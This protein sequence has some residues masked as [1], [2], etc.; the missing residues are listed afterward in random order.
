MGPLHDVTKHIE[1]WL[2]ERGLNEDEIGRGM[3]LL[4]GEDWKRISA[5]ELM[6]RLRAEGFTMSDKMPAF[7]DELEGL[8]RGALKLEDFRRRPI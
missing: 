1:S 2:T 8:V 5:S 3:K 4:L 6:N 7:A